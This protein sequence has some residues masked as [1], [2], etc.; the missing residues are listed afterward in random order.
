MSYIQWIR[1]KVGHD[2]IFL[3]FA[4]GCIMNDNGEILLQKRVDKNLWVFPG[5]ALELGES[6]EESLI[7][8]VEEETG[9]QV[10]VTS[11]LGIYTKYY[12]EYPSGAIREHIRYC[13]RSG[14]VFDLWIKCFFLFRG[15]EMRTLAC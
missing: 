4:S 2:C 3:N 13:R 10:E 6:A 12:D 14:T 11:L 7:R 1:N 8:E 15:R 5:G 9:L